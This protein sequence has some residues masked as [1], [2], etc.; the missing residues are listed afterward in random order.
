[1]YTTNDVY[2]EVTTELENVKETL[3][4]SHAKITILLQEELT[5]EEVHEVL[6]A[7]DLI[8][9]LYDLVTK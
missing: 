6:S 5:N 2:S 1:M 4:H 7:R 9:P 8:Y 3:V